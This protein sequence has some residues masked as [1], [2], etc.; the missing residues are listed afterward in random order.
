MSVK[1]EAPTFEEQVIAYSKL[2]EVEYDKVRKQLAKELNVRVKTLDD[3]IS[4]TRASNDDSDDGSKTENIIDLVKEAGIILFHDD[5]DI[6]FA[7]VTVDQHVEVWPIESKQFKKWLNRIFWNKHGKP[8]KDQQRKD[9]I[10]TLLGLADIDGQ[11]LKVYLRAAYS[12]GKHYLDLC[13]KE[14]RVIEIDVSGW[15][16]LDRS[17]VKFRRTA[18]MQALPVPISGGDHTLLWDLINVTEGDRMFILTWI[19]DSMREN[20][21]CPVLEIVGGHGSAKSTVHRFIRR[22]FDPNTV[23]LRGAPSK[24]SDVWV[25]VKSNRCISYENMS[26]ASSSMQDTF[27]IIGTGGGHAGRALYSDYDEVVVKA[28]NP[29]IIN[30]IS[31]VITAG[32]L[33][34]RAIRIT[35]PKLDSTK[36]RQESEISAAFSAAQQSIFSGILDVFV[37]ALSEIDKIVIHKKPRML[38]YSILGEA[39]GNVTGAKE[40]FNEQY[41]TMREKLL[42]HATQGCLAMMAIGLMVNTTGTFNGTYKALLI[43]LDDHKLKSGGNDWPA[44]PRKLSALIVRHEPGLNAMGIQITRN[45]HSRE[46]N[47]IKIEVIK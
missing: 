10:S 36:I 7:E 42:I 12:D 17:P 46:G 22:L 44:T 18:T 26:V 24:E 14:W 32:D 21:Q 45:D 3:E 25:A 40:S 41:M 1:T 5:M 28:L 20:T 9:A 2:S 38:D 39:I 19:I 29:I 13:D 15:R 31:P 27:C 33:A 35:V 30:G 47:T 43:R 16:V 4:K 11:E 6:A 8:L 37:A 23:D 34:D